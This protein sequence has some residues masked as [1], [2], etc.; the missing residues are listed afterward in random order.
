MIRI[1]TSFFKKKEQF[2]LYFGLIG[3]SPGL[4][5][6][7]YY[8]KFFGVSGGAGSPNLLNMLSTFKCLASTSPK[9]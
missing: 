5:K 6:A 2:R 3:T 7:F 1:A 8:Q 4:P 9:S